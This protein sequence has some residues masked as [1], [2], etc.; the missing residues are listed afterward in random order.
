MSSNFAMSVMCIAE[1]LLWATLAVLF[2]S[3][4]LRRRFSAMGA[5]IT[6]H[7]ISAPLLAVALMDSLEPRLHR[8]LPALPPH[9]FGYFYYIGYWA[10]EAASAVLLYFICLE[11]FRS[12][13]APFP[14]LARLGLVVVRWAAVISL[15]VTV[16]TTSSKFL[17][18]APTYGNGIYALVPAVTWSLVRSVSLL[19]LCLLAF[20]CLSMNALRLPIRDVAFGLP[21]GFGVM[22][23]S[24]F[25]LSTFMSGRTSLTAPIQFLCESLTLLALAAWIAYC[26]MPEPVRK[27]VVVPVT[28]RIFRWNDIASAL[29]HT[30]TRVA[31]Q[32][33]ANSFFLTD[34][35]KVVE[36]VLSRNLQSHESES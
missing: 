4:G 22:S 15:I 31:V 32:Q 14:G 28:S 23:T 1:L 36:K 18:L 3:K 33:P 17:A 27:P 24:D 5:Y 9:F 20:L 29:G 6:L 2:W 13:L 11:V 30:G 25:I 10:V 35:E 16:T 21:L 19:E 34:V 7:A 8:F 26:A 12:A